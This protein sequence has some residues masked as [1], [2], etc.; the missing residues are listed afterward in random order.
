M[1]AV[2][3]FLA[4]VDRKM[5]PRDEFAER[6][7]DE[8]L[9]TKTRRKRYDACDEL[10]SIYGKDTPIPYPPFTKIANQRK[11][12]TGTPHGGAAHLR[13]TSVLRAKPWRRA[14]SLRS[15]ISNYRGVKRPQGAEP[16]KEDMTFVM[17]SFLS[18]VGEKD[19]FLKFACKKSLYDSK[20]K[21]D[22]Q[23]SLVFRFFSC[24]RGCAFQQV[25]H[26][27]IELC[28]VLGGNDGNTC[29]LLYCFSSN[30]GG[31]TAFAGNCYIF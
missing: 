4:D 11:R 17:S 24:V 18:H 23:N 12:M 13:R 25:R 9:K 27:L 20:N 15:G 7:R 10:S 30:S 1:K 19:G 31:L 26:N 14:H 8:F 6:A 22:A 21:F 5:R 29:A 2:S 28:R 16:K 3:S